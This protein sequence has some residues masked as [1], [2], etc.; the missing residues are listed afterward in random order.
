MSDQWKE[1]K[2]ERAAVYLERTV[3]DAWGENRDSRNYDTY[4]SPRF[5]SGLR[6]DGLSEDINHQNKATE[7]MK[8]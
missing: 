6:P 7:R 2:G 5:G 8:H 1:V 4:A 3:A